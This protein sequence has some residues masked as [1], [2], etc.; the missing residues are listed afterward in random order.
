[1]KWI[2]MGIKLFGFIIEALRKPRPESRPNI[3]DP[4]AS[5][6]KW[7]NLSSDQEYQ[8]HKIVKTHPMGFEMQL[9]WVFKL[10][11]YCFLIFTTGLFL[12]YIKDPVEKEIGEIMIFVVIVV[13]CYVVIYFKFMT[14]K[15]FDL[16]NGYYWTRYSL[17]SNEIPN[18]IRKKRFGKNFTRLDEIHA[19]QI[20]DA[21]RRKMMYELNLVLKNGN[22][23]H[24]VMYDDP[25]KA[26]QD[27]E[28]LANHL[29]VP[30]WNDSN[31]QIL[32]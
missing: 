20:K 6:T 8:T 11:T 16:E 23:I 2:K 15:C 27:F 13:F 22:R 32:Q 21:I 18:R 12:A 5:K 19:L 25:Q 26:R 30:L 28:N 9:T 7:N 29:Q 24:V 14:T 3:N 31:I 1:M 17:M 4:I 10:F